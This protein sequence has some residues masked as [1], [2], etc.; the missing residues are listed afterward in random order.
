[1]NSKTVL[2]KILTLL[3][4]ESEVEL[5]YAKLADGTIVESKTFDVG[6]ELFVVSEDGTKTPAPNGTHDLM[7]KD[8][9]GEENLIKV[10]TEDGKIIEREN[11]ELADVK[12]ED[13]PQAS[14]DVPESEILPDETNQVK[15]GTLKMEEE[16]EEVS[17]LPETDG[18]PMEDEDEDG[19]IA[20]G[21]KME[22]MA[23]RIE[24]ME[25]KMQSMEA[26][27]PPVASEVVQEE[28]GI[29][30]SEEEELPKLDGAPVEE[31]ANVRFSAE[32]RNYGKKVIDS[33]STF[34][35]KLYN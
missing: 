13:I 24:E 35:A 16:T 5:T 33:Q 30:M 17:P 12:T 1:M 19:V 34:L 4:L 31:G 25:K 18:E 14:G 22:E 15:S 6:E 32:K 7:L 29:K 23:Y 2:G 10:K 3:S 8:E 28:E 26:M 21:K 20:L 11:V 9:S 27:F